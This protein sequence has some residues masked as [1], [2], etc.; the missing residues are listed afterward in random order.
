[1]DEFDKKIQSYLQELIHDI[2]KENK[3]INELH[4]CSEVDRLFSD[5]LYSLIQNQYETLPL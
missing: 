5:N 2:Y 3:T 4:A 1:L